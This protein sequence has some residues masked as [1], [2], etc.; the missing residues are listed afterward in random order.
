MNILVS[1]LATSKNKKRLELLAKG[2]IRSK[3]NRHKVI[4]NMIADGPRPAFLPNDFNWIEYHEFGISHKHLQGLEYALKDN[5]IDFAIF[6]DDDV[7][8]DIDTFVE[9]AKENFQTATIWTTEPGMNARE[10]LKNCLNKY[11]PNLMS[12]QKETQFYLGFCTS[13]VNK[14]FLDSLRK[15][16]QALDATWSASRELLSNVFVPDI[17]LSVIAYLMGANHII[18]RNHMGTCWPSFCSSSL[19]SKTGKMWHVHG[20]RETTYPS[21]TYEA[22]ENVITRCPQDNLAINSTI[23]G[24]L[25]FGFKARDWVDIPLRINWFFQPWVQ[26]Y[27]K[28]HIMKI[29]EKTKL[30]CKTDS[31]DSGTI[32]IEN[33]QECSWQAC[34]GGLMILPTHGSPIRMAWKLSENAIVGMR[35]HTNGGIEDSM[36]WGLWAE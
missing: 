20:F 18:G 34:A 35:E 27:P 32:V 9:N 22:L 2:T 30:L 36:L 17:Q 10:D 16:R 29:S 31:K 26:R 21:I 23:F 24:E 7:V 3:S 19:L 33:G 15:N 14:P 4:V 12:A 25:E 1:I 8:I 13:V 5:N 28:E 11:A 6:C